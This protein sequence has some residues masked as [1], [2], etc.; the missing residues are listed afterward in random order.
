MVHSAISRPSH[1]QDRPFTLFSM[2]GSAISASPPAPE[3]G[4]SSPTAATSI[5]DPAVAAGTASRCGP[6][7]SQPGTTDEEV[8]NS[9]PPRPSS[10]GDASVAAGIHAALGDLGN[11]GDGAAGATSEIPSAAAPSVSPAGESAT[12]GTPST[13]VVSTAASRPRW[14]PGARA[15]LTAFA[16]SNVYN[17][18]IAGEDLPLPPADTEAEAERLIA[19][20]FSLGRRYGPFVV[21]RVE[22]TSELLRLA[23]EGV[24]AST[25]RTSSTDLVSVAVHY[26][27]QRLEEE[28]DQAR[29]RVKELESQLAT[30]G[31]AGP[32]EMAEL[33]AELVLIKASYEREHLR[34]EKL[35]RQI[36]DREAALIVAKKQISGDQ[37]IA[38]R[39]E[40]SLRALRE[41]LVALKKTSAADPA[42]LATF[43]SA[44]TDFVGDR[45]RL[46]A[47]IRSANAGT[48]EPAAAD[49]A[50]H[51][52]RRG[53]SAATASGAG[54][55][56]GTPSKA[57]ATLTS[58]AAAIPPNP[59]IASVGARLLQFMPRD[60]RHSVLP[61]SALTLPP[62]MR[63]IDLPPAVL[64]LMRNGDSYEDAV[65]DL[66][67]GHP[68]HTR[69]RDG[70]LVEVLAELM[71]HQEL[72]DAHW[73]EAVPQTYLDRAWVLS[74]TPAPQ[75][76]KR[77]NSPSRSQTSPP[78]KRARPTTPS[79]SGKQRRLS[80]SGVESSD[81][82][83]AESEAEYEAGVSSSDPYAYSTTHGTLRRASTP[84][85]PAQS[86]RGASRRQ[87]GA[88]F[89]P[90][91]SIV[92]LSGDAGQEDD[93]S[94]EK[95]PGSVSKRIYAGTSP[96]PKPKVFDIEVFTSKN[97]D[98]PEFDF[99][100]FQTGEATRL[101]DRWDSGAYRRLLSSA[102][103]D[104]MFQHRHKLLY[105][106]RVTH[107][108]PDVLAW[109]G[110]L[111]KV[112][113]EHRQAF[114]ERTHWMNIPDSEL[115]HRERKKRADALRSIMKRLQK[116]EKALRD[117]DFI[118]TWFWRGEPAL[119]FS[120]PTPMTWVIEAPSARSYNLQLLDLDQESPVRVYWQDDDQGFRDICPARVKM[121]SDRKLAAN[122]LP[123]A[124]MRL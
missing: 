27:G 38:R 24:F 54:S 74:N 72:A 63:I 58:L 94:E 42:R 5:T 120:P 52:E 20:A 35:L 10:G 19:R 6:R 60:D 123:S 40:E 29:R 84:S 14:S 1:T 30:Y 44:N 115:Q 56:V 104:A 87:S 7:S 39:S 33:R 106:H 66:A 85:S 79:S 2:T 92:G 13:A 18:I 25:G 90:P 61:D 31:A 80:Y 97:A 82:S 69:F 21:E 122:Q 36:R 67:G 53:S 124:D 114:W 4:E 75:S 93:S 45:D 26:R 113:I 9:S 108:D 88:N 107:L 8:K 102:P 95:A 28:R 81:E 70:P 3:A 73:T 91:P 51:V 55:S 68:V 77:N 46:A 65:S 49:T 16:G 50:L 121:L 78:A 101:R 71:R 41:E 117:S 57:A 89:A 64:E 86:T 119:W 32:T 22:R 37:R 11:T 43:L 98:F 116:T 99:L 105:Y 47:L 23:M 34:S 118:S 62:G 48:L 103:W 111:V 83:S 112:M 59:Y 17:D 12:P 100:T 15:A 96:T 109:V 110:D 76:S